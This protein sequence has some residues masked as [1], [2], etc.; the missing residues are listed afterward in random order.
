MLQVYELQMVPMDGEKFRTRFAQ[1]IAQ[2]KNRSLPA[3]FG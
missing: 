2:K 3:M 1:Q